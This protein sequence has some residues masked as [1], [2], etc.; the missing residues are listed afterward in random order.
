MS[1]SVLEQFV[2]AA[3][4]ILVAP[5][6]FWKQ[7]LITPSEAGTAAWAAVMPPSRARAVPPPSN[8]LF[9]FDLKRPDLRSLRLDIRSGLLMM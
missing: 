1:L 5:V 4:M 8:S 9:F 3:S 7:A 6:D 2:L